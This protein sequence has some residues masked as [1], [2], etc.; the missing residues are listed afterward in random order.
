VEACGWQGGELD[1]AAVKAIVEVSQHKI[2]AMVG[3]NKNDHRLLKFLCAWHGFSNEVVWWST[4]QGFPGAKVVCC[5]H[6]EP[7]SWCQ[8]EGDNGIGQVGI[9]DI[10]FKDPMKL[11]TTV[12]VAVGCMCE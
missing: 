8:R 7:W 10:G 2:S 3:E 1:R 11:K 6:G 4:E 12:F 5:E 9:R